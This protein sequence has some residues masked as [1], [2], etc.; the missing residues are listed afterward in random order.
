MSDLLPDKLLEYSVVYTDRALNHMSQSFP[1]RH[2]RYLYHTQKSVS[3]QR[4]HRRTR[5]WHVW[6]GSRSATIC[7]R[8]K[9]S[10]NSQWMVQL[11]LEPNSSKWATSHPNPSSSK[12]G[13]WAM[14]NTPLMHRHLL[15]RSQRQSSRKNRTLSSRHTSKPHPGIILPDDYNPFRSRCRTRCWRPPG[16]GLH[17]LGNNLGSI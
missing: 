11:S 17:R 6:H 13:A 9:M 1:G 2:A 3:R 10:Y 7:H 14:T 4:G 8:Q 5:Q 16:T 12:R 15:K